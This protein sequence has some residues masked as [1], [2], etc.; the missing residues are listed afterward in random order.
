MVFAT[1]ELQRALEEAAA[2]R[3]DGR[4][5]ETKAYWASE[6]CAVKLD[7]AF[8]SDA[9]VGKW[10]GVTPAPSD[11]HGRLTQ[12]RV[13]R[14]LYLHFFMRRSAAPEDAPPTDYGH[15]YTLWARACSLLSVAVAALEQADSPLFHDAVLVG[16][17]V[18]SLTRKMESAQ[19]GNQADL[20][21]L[22]SVIEENVGLPI[23]ERTLEEIT[24]AERVILESI[25]WQM[26]TTDTFTVLSTLLLRLDIATRGEHKQELV[27]A[28]DEAVKLFLS[29]T[30]HGQANGYATAR[31][32][33][34]AASA[35]LHNEPA[36]TTAL[37]LAA[38]AA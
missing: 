35:P 32:I 18:L 15:C 21:K 28:W 22:T 4:E 36:F 27:Q 37:E 10:S 7:R 30:L 20:L 24:A 1:Q 13:L 31:R 26:P 19:L 8:A 14:T 17:A 6:A 33:V 25:G 34:W 11:Q 29:M 38:P 9:L 3:A 2:V 16:V 23:K 5:A 12:M